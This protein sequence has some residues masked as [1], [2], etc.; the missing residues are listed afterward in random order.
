MCRNFWIVTLWKC[1]PLFF[2]PWIKYFGY[3]PCVCTAMGYAVLLASTPTHVCA[4]DSQPQRWL[5]CNA[6]RRRLCQ[7]NSSLVPPPP[8]HTHTPS[9]SHTPMSFTIWPMKKH[10]HTLCNAQ[11]ILWFFGSAKTSAIAVTFR[12]RHTCRTAVQINSCVLPWFSYWTI[13][14][15]GQLQVTSFIIDWIRSVIME[16]RSKTVSSRASGSHRWVAFKS[17]VFF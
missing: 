6:M 3:S 14:C 1:P 11:V 7:V 4:I 15:W 10:Q 17:A 9:L 12:F 5:H 16:R 2:I 13:P 8:F